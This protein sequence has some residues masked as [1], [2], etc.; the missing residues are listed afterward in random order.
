[1]LKG[2]L[3]FAGFVVTDW[4]A[5]NK[6]PGDYDHQ[7]EAAINAGIDMVMVPTNYRDFITTMKELVAAGRIPLARIDD[8]VRRILRQKVRFG[9]WERAARRPPSDRRRSARPRTARSPVRPCARA[10]C[11]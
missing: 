4:E 8:A 7:V 6:L 11:C 3:G 10:W 9:L 2:E 1:M 5:L